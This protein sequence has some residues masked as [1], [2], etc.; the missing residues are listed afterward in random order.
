MQISRSCIIHQVQYYETD[1]MRIAHHSN[2]VKWMEEARQ[3]F[4]KQAGFDWK[5][6]E[7][8]TGIMIPVLFQS[9]EYKQMIKFDENVNI[10][11]TCNKFN[12][13]KM[14]FTYDFC[15][16]GSGKI[17]AVGITKHGFIDSAYKPIAL[18]EGYF[19]GYEQLRKFIKSKAWY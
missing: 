5:R 16:A 7:E 3:G 19:E 12:G 18:Q 17:R 9:V 2:Y 11:C 1:S 6:M 4:F 10:I 15:I 14:E 8:M 13:V